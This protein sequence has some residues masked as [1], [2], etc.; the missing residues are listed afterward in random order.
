MP[1][2]F[3]VNYVIAL[4]LAVHAVRTGRNMYWIMILILFPVLGSLI[5]LFA[6]LL[7]GLSGGRT[8]RKAGVVARRA[9]DPGR[10]ARLALDQLEVTRTPANLKAAADAL[11][12]VGRAHEALALYEEATAGAFAD[13]PAMLAGR[14][15]ASF[16]TGA[17]ARALTSLDRLRQLEPRA[18]MPE[19]HLLYARALEALGRNEEALKEYHAVGLYYPGAEALAREAMLL[20]RLERVD[21]AQP[22]WAQILAGAR[23]APKFARRAQQRWI[24]LARSRVR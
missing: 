15:R 17:H 5:Y 12:G 2:L 1:V 20:D 10:E 4:G 6:E 8:A 7:P 19:E 3:V 9:I 18:R 21:E 22:I 11:L 24:D 13:D 14:A 16:E 23:I